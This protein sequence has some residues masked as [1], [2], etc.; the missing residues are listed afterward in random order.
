MKSVT[1]LALSLIVLA[2]CSKPGPQNQSSV[3]QPTPKKFYY[4]VRKTDGKMT[5]LEPDIGEF[6]DAQRV[7]GQLTG[8]IVQTSSGA[9]EKT[10]DG[11]Y[12]YT[13]FVADGKDIEVID[14]TGVYHSVGSTVA[15][16]AANIDKPDGSDLEFLQ[17]GVE[18]K[19]NTGI[20]SLPGGGSMTRFTYQPKKSAGNT[21]KV[22]GEYRSEGG[23]G[24][25]ISALQVKTD[26]G[27][28]QI[29]LD[30]LI[31]FRK[32]PPTPSPSK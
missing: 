1:I 31:P 14:N 18:P 11:K 16:L 29:P 20:L 22:L 30:Q 24:Q 2:F 3:E 15:L 19:G 25:I 28:T 7:E 32:R 10:K 27:V 26:S 9:R 8:Y 6:A 23:K 4:F 12:I 21:L 13:Y 17:V 5:A